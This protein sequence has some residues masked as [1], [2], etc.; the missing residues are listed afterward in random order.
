MNTGRIIGALLVVL[1]ILG[2]AYGGFSYTHKTKEAQIGPLALS[3]KHRHHVAIPLWMGL[4]LSHSFCWTR[5]RRFANMSA[6][7]LPDGN[8]PTPPSHAFGHGSRA[9]PH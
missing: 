1:G 6:C 7:R 3:V 4:I 2:A 5:A 9:T 8:F